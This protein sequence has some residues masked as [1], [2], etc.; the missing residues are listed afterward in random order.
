MKIFFV[1]Q[2]VGSALEYSGDILLSWMRELPGCEILNYKYQNPSPI[3]YNEIE[4]F[5]PDILILNEYYKRVIEAAY[6]WKKHKP[7]TKL[8]FINYVSSTIIGKYDDINEGTFF[9]KFFLD[10]V[11]YIFTLNDLEPGQSFPEKLKSK[12]E[13]WFCPTDPEVFKVITP[14]NKRSKK[15]LYLGNILPHKIDLEF[16]DLFAETDLTLDCYGRIFENN[17]INEKIKSAKNINLKGCVP[18]LDVPK[19]FNEYRYFVLP[20][21]NVPEPFNWALLQA[22]FCGTIPLVKNDPSYNNSWL[23]WA[24]GLYFGVNKSE[25]L[26]KNMKELLSCRKN[27]LPI[28][29]A[30]SQKAQERFD[31]Y[32]MKQR[33]Q[34]ILIE[35]MSI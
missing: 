9:Q 8:F 14:W 1:N 31:Y 22:M 5:N 25:S 30:I 34:E 6:F 35:W 33:F 28:S 11:D 24:N 21:A 16:I 13:T 19:V 15:F 12:I 32:E 3:I 26:V 7:S 4:K 29:N 27:L 10:I 20:H 2:D 23:N 18:Q 17:E